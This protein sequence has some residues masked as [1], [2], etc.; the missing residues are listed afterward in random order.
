MEWILTK[1]HVPTWE[2]CKGKIVLTHVT[3]NSQNFTSPIIF[4]QWENFTAYFETPPK[5]DR[6]IILDID[7]PEYVA[8]VEPVPCRVCGCLPT[9]A[10]EPENS[11]PFKIECAGEEH[12]IALFAS[13]RTEA[14]Q[15]WNKHN[16]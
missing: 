5:I 4:Q 2:E 7:I 9:I 11:L 6:Y 3:T 15:L 16:A 1:D 10:K 12:V 8:P 13:T 14:V